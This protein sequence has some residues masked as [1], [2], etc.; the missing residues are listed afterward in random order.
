[1]TDDKWVADS[2]WGRAGRGHE[3]DPPS[4]SLRRDRHYG[5]Y[6]TNAIGAHGTAQ[7]RRGLVR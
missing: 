5:T 6:E 1:M 2:V 4:P 3:W 7:N